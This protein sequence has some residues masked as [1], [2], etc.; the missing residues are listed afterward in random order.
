[1]AD[2]PSINNKAELKSYLKALNAAYLE[3]IQE[4][5]AAVVTFQVTASDMTVRCA[6]P[7][8]VKD[9]IAVGIEAD[10]NPSGNQQV[11]EFTFQYKGTGLVPKP[12]E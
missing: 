4:I 2:S 7:A 1:M 10:T 3:T 5:N 6:C 11:C 8:L 12:P 9:N